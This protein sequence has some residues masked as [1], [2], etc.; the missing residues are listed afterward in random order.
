MKTIQVDQTQVF[1]NVIGSGEP[2]LFLHGVPD[3]SDIWIKTLE[4]LSPDYLCLAP[5]LPG[6]GRTKAPKDFDYSLNNLADFIDKL[7]VAQ[8]VDVPINL[9]LHDIGG[10]V[11]LAWAIQNAE[12][13][14]SL[15]IM[16][17]VFFSDY[18]WHAM[19]KTWRKPVLGELA[20][21]FMGL[22]R[23]KQAMNA[24]AKSFTDQQIQ[25]S[26][27]HL[28]MRNRMMILKFYRALDPIMFTGWE[29]RLL[30]LTRRVPTLV[31]WGE[32]DKYL[33]VTLAKRF[34]TSNIDTIKD[35]G[36]WPMQDHPERVAK[37][38]KALIKKSMS[39]SSL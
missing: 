17:T 24:G 15:T 1:L 37:G 12:K 8:K 29:D 38:I 36:H 7:V 5:D 23:F 22:K 4:I 19:A 9:V 28:S 30:H 3:T 35:C 21:L 13:V 10:I 27:N 34:G 2:I 31:I 16:S 25:Q 26:Y 20:M 39:K 14:K 18:Q 11:G 6:F 32:K 33:P